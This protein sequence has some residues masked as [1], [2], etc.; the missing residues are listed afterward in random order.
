MKKVI[1]YLLR[2]LAIENESR[3]E[4]SL[5]KNKKLTKHLQIYK[6][7]KIFGTFSANV[8]RVLFLFYSISIF[9][10]GS[11]ISPPPPPLLE[12]D[13]FQILIRPR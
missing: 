8:A 3:R 13:H 1:K 7:H 12:D 11:P 4:V 10:G 6:K 5:V 9:L 2:T